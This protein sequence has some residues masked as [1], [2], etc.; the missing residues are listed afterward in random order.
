MTAQVITRAAQIR[1]RRLD[2][3]SYR[4]IVSGEDLPLIAAV[5]TENVQR[6]EAAGT[7]FRQAEAHAL[8]EEG[9]TMEEIGR[10]FGLTRQRI[11]ALLRGVSHPPD[12]PAS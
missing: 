11:S 1:A 12:R 9:M 10:L 3:L 7:R 2:G 8:H 4:E 6:L 5:L